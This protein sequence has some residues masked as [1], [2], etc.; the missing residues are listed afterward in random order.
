MSDN[1]RRVGLKIGQRVL[2]IDANG[3]GIV[4]R[5]VV[6]VVERLSGNYCVVLKD[7]PY[8]HSLRETRFIP[9]TELIM[10]LL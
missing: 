4:C 3:S 7:I 2:C 8:D 6:Y 5:G 1:L 9:A 10:E